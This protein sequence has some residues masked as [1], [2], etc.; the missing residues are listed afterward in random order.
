MRTISLIDITGLELRWIREKV[1]LSRPALATLLKREKFDG[2]LGSCVKSLERYERLATVPVLFAEHYR[3]IIGAETFD[4]LL[5]MA[6]AA[7]TAGQL[8]EMI[9]WGRDRRKALNEHTR[10]EP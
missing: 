3:R 7:T 2:E 10:E 1:G 6:R 4:E 9:K 8:H 5:Q